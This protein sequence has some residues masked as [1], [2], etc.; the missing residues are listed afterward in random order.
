[1]KT[2]R[3]LLPLIAVSLFATHCGDDS[4]P[5][6]PRL[7]DA[8]LI[9]GTWS[10]TLSD[11]K[12]ASCPATATIEQRSG[13]REIVTG[14]IRSTCF[15]FR[16]EAEM[17]DPSGRGWELAGRASYFYDIG[18]TYRATMHGALDGAPVSR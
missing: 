4:G 11:G 16:F 2:A 15:P 18:E 5:T 8:P 13:A 9:V 17:R 6:A 14:N 1:M 12:G 10:G 7:S 3:T